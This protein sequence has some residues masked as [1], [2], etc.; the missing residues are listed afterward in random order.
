MV[1]GALE[2]FDF[3]DVPNLITE[4]RWPNVTVVVFPVR[5]SISMVRSLLSLKENWG[6]HEVGEYRVLMRD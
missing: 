5:C 2:S 4:Q 1:G 3:T 6:E